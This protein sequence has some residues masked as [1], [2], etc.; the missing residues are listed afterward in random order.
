MYN[1]LQFEHIAKL[2]AHKLESISTAASLIVQNIIY[3]ITDLENKRKH[4]KKQVNEPHQFSK[5]VHLYI[6]EIFRCLLEIISDP[7][8]SGHGRDNCIDLCLKFVDTANGCGWTSKF[9]AQGV[10]KLLKVASSMPELSGTLPITEHTKMH[11]ACCL[12]TVYDDLYSDKARDEYIN[13]CDKY[14]Q[15]VFWREFWIWNFNGFLIGRLWRKM[16]MRRKLRQLLL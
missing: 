12:S 5:E 7:N 1:A 11:I 16:M 3:A 6:E 10:P 4:V 15:Y 2:I 9:V 13:E 8:C 14:I